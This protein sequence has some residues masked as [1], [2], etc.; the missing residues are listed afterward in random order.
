[1]KKDW[2][3]FLKQLKAWHDPSKRKL[4]W[5]D[6]DDAYLVWVSE[7]FLQ[8][9]QAD[10]VIE[11]WLR[12]TAKFPTIE[13]LAEASFEEALPY[14]KGLGFYGRLR[15]MLLTA[16][17]VVENHR[18]QIREEKMKIKEEDE[19]LRRA[20]FPRELDELE[21]L[22]GIGPYTARAVASFAYGQ[23]VLAPDTNVVR[24]ISRYFGVEKDLK[25]LKESKDLK[26]LKGKMNKWVM[27]NLEFFDAHYPED[28]SLNQVLMDFGSQ[29][30]KARTP[31]CEACPLI[32]KCEY[33]RAP[34]QFEQLKGPINKGQGSKREQRSLRSYQKIV[35]G[36]LI[37]DKSVLVSRRKADQTFAG[38][39]EFPGGKLEEGEDLRAAMQREFREEVGV[40][41]SVRPA[42]EKMAVHRQKLLLHF[43]RCRVLTG[44]IKMKEGD[45]DLRGEEGQELM[46]I[47]QEDLD[48][49]QFLPANKSI[50]ETLKKSRM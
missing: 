43:H 23:K 34:E 49:K 2:N 12:F 3:W 26:D 45:E 19:D 13:D 7:V 18:R 16:E 50:I 41:V 4:P 6:L 40:E 1:M 39:L 28:F 24:I 42:F 29:I 8:Q 11:F 37:Q 25:D 35:V 17:A 14:F 10:R 9:T 47:R 30:C 33:G 27:K 46:W 22:P 44:K 48:P 5:K 36:I 21:K 15:R 31:Q 38:L 20:R 32:K